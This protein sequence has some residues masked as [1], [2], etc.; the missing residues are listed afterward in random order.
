MAAWIQ[1]D[2][3][4][5]LLILKWQVKTWKGSS[6][7]STHLEIT[8]QLN[9]KLQQESGAIVVLLSYNFPFIGLF[10]QSTH[11][12][13]LYGQLTFIESELY[14]HFVLDFLVAYFTMTKMI[15]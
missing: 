8:T 5:Y 3:A 14:R 1:F 10:S 7:C 4:H 15:I 11:R 6:K 13:H 2:P 12:T 9:T